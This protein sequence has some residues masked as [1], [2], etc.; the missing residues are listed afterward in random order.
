MYFQSGLG[1]TSS[2]LGACAVPAAVTLRRL[3]CTAA[4]RTAIGAALGLGRDATAA[5]VR[6]IITDAVRRAV[7]LIARA[8]AP[9]R[10]PRAAAVAGETMRLRFRDAFGTAPEFFPTWRPAEQTWDRGAVVRERLR[11]A[12]KIMSEGDI[13]FVCWGPGSCPFEFDWGPG[14]WAVVLPGQYRICLGARFWRASREGD[15][16]GLATTLLH[17]CLHIYFDTIRHRLERGPYNTAACYERYV[18]VAN[19]LAVPDAVSMPC[20][21]KIPM[22]DFPLPRAGANRMA[23]LG[24]LG[25]PTTACKPEPGEIAASRTAAGILYQGR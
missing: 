14:T 15:A 1:G 22:G 16:D 20:P 24:S 25:Q 18:L 3:V 10:R 7:V 11:C 23:G 8:A 2:G 6:T 21:S 9:L 19:G 12:A 4:D 5:E 13:E 17:E